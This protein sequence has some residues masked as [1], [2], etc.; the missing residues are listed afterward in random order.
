MRVGS[1]RVRRALSAEVE[2]QLDT[3]CI[4]SDQSSNPQTENLNGGDEDYDRYTEDGGATV[5]GYF[6]DYDN[7]GYVYDAPPDETR[8]TWKT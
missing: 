5:D 1:I 3:A 7:G 6:S 8:E 2:C 4:A